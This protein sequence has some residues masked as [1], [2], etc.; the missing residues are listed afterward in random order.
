MSSDSS[1]P[2]STEGPPPTT[3]NGSSG[4]RTTGVGIGGV[5]SAT[6]PTTAS[7]AA[8]TTSP[9]GS[10]GSGNSNTPTTPTVVGSVI[11]GL[12]GL[13]LILVLLL[14]LF[15]RHKRRLDGQRALPSARD[16]AQPPPTGT[17]AMS[18]PSSHTPLTSAVTPAFLSRWR[19]SGQSAS[20]TE[21]AAPAERGF[22]KLGGRKIEGVLS[23]KD[24]YGGD[25]GVFQ[26]G[27]SAG[28]GAA[29]A[30]DG[31]AASSTGG[32]EL[33]GK[34]FYR[35][36]AGFYGGAG[37]VPQTPVTASASRGFGA[38]NR[39]SDAPSE[40]AVMRPSPARTPVTS[41]PPET[42]A[43]PTRLQQQD[44]VGRSHPDGS[45]G[46]RFTESV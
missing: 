40:I 43:V 15:R 31:E 41:H 25:Y 12:A 22:Q 4:S 7:G 34:S 29:A 42:P 3:S 6:S 9:G 23:G 44:G 27:A 11:G 28:A 46:S 14:Y 26:Q 39:D 38:G 1:A 13:T 32:R 17:T 36:S 19:Q 5:A 35:D 45:K 10:S 8:A 20:T 24:Q 16:S 30:R 21:S 2:S 37:S 33:A 18:E